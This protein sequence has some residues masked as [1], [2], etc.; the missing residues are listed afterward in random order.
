MAELTPISQWMLRQPQQR[1]AWRAGGRQ[2]TGEFVRRVDAWVSVLGAR[3]G[4]RFAL[5]HGDSSEFLAIL[6]AL[7]HLRRIA[8]IASDN[9]PGT[10]AMLQAHVDAFIGDFPATENCI[11]SA[12]DAAAKPTQWSQLDSDGVSLEIYTSG[13]SGSPRAI[14]KTLAQLQAEVAA[15]EA[16]WPGVADSAVLTTVSHQHFYGLMIALLWPFSAGRC[17]A[18]RICDFPEDIIHRGA[19]LERFYLVSSPSHLARFSPAFDWHLLAGRC[20]GAVSSAAPLQ[21]AD[22]LKAATLLGAPVRE[23]Y[24][25]SETGA[26]AWRCQ[27]ETD[28]DAAWQALP[29]VRLCATAESTLAVQAPYLDVDRQVLPDRVEFDAEGRFRLLGR[30]DRI[31]KVEGKRVSLSAIEDRLRAH[32]GVSEVR[33][34]VLERG[35][36]ETA[37]V[38]QLT[39]A[40]DARLQR[41]GRKALIGELKALLAGQL[42]AVVMP[43]RWRFVRRMPYNSQGKLPL[44]D[45]QALFSD[46]ARWPHI[47]RRRML[48]DQLILHCRIPPGLDYFDGHILGRPILPG[49]VQLH[50][51]EAFARRWLPLDGQFEC[52][53]AVKFQQVI[54][55]HFEVKVSLAF[56]ADSGKLT[57]CYESERGVH[58]RGRICFRR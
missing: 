14:T 31:V 10:V 36:V 57:F 23:I 37:V 27:Q 25:S 54:L 46:D 39:E 26:I 43:R 34:L 12:A 9:Q 28:D 18:A 22:S 47:L 7:W 41:D 58:S 2:D 42:E 8:C 40:D 33:A 56:N 51:A 21:R 16:Q 29:G 19:R 44:P 52:L 6:L 50:W 11:A 24:G 35:R 53:E 13:S 1:V 15:L 3:P 55:P 17:F 49:I 32:S 45:L 38:V 48:G 4:K 5:Y 20:V 30:V